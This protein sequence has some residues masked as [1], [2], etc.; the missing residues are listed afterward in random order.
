MSICKIPRRIT[1]DKHGTP[2]IN[3][4]RAK[5]FSFD[6]TSC[7]LVVVDPADTNVFLADNKGI[8]V[9]LLFLALFR[10]LFMTIEWLVDQLSLNQK[11]EYIWHL[12]TIANIQ[13]KEFNTSKINK[14]DTGIQFKEVGGID[15]IKSKIMDAISMMKGE[16][17]WKKMEVKMP[18]GILLAGPPGTGKTLLAKAMANEARIP[19][20]SSNGAEFVDMYQGVS[21]S[22]VRSLFAKR[23]GSS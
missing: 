1:F 14:M 10:F 13:S 3:T 17:I 2:T 11:D 20:F 23:S 18:R 7:E 21:A 6:Q 4:C 8:F 12:E 5:I 15:Q 22:R 9:A 19:F 16:P